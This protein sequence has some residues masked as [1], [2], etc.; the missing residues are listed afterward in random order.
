MGFAYSSWVLACIV[1]GQ[2]VGCIKEYIYMTI[3]VNFHFARQ[4]LAFRDC[5]VFLSLVILMFDWRKFGIVA[6]QE[7]PSFL[8]IE[9]AITMCILERVQVRDT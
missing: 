5:F 8:T 4:G 2:H 3:L 7:V 1:S 9:V 6:R